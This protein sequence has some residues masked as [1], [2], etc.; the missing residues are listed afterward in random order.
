MYNDF[1]YDILILNEL[2]VCK[3]NNF[4]FA[5]HGFID[6]LRRC[7]EFYFHSLA[8]FINVKYD[9]FR[10]GVN[11]YMFFVLFNFDINQYLY[12][13]DN[14]VK[15][16][17]EQEKAKKFKDN[18][19]IEA[20]CQGQVVKYCKTNKIPFPQIKI[21]QFGKA[22][23]VTFSISE[24]NENGSLINPKLLPYLSDDTDLPE[25]DSMYSN[26]IGRD[27]LNDI[28]SDIPEAIAPLLALHGRLDAALFHISRDIREADLETSDLLH[29]CE[30]SNPN[31]AEGYKIFKEL[32]KC[33][34]RR[35]EAKDKL[36]LLDIIKN[37]GVIDVAH[38]FNEQYNTYQSNLKTRVY[39]PRVR[40]DLFP[41]M[42]DDTSE[43]ECGEENET[44]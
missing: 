40:K 11:G 19:H 18:T 7:K 1:F 34:I 42:C 9:T 43:T 33:R 6:V 13:K 20:F 25:D 31:A 12:W 38:N 27:E 3:R 22:P 23:P 16:T 39:H 44:E 24:I 5:A 21:V 37:S 14:K 4:V 35:R 32:K 8:D 28:L 41:D 29:K 10:K 30:F 15:W 26:D 36:R 17:P 2:F